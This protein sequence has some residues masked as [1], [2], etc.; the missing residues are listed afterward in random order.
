M[1]STMQPTD[2]VEITGETPAPS[3]TAAA[4]LEYTKQHV[5]QWLREQIDEA[6]RIRMATVEPE[7]IEIFG[8][9]ADMLLVGPFQF[10]G[11]PG[12]PPFP[13]SDVVRVGEQAIVAVIQVYAPLPDVAGTAPAFALPYEIRLR[14]GS[15]HSWNLAEPALQQTING[16]LAANNLVFIDF[17]VFTPTQP[18]LCEMNA[19]IDVLDANNNPSGVGGFARSVIPVA[20]PVLFPV[21]PAPSDT[22][23]RFAAVAT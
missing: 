21:D 12:N 7:A 11:P 10:F 2:V 19:W 22:G 13:P 9:T 8:G 23:L 6:L 20:P 14:T 4:D 1:A 17:F 3:T 15:L 16:N 5:G 18:D